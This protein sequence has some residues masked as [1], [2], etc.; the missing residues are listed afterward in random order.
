MRVSVSLCLGASAGMLLVGF[1]ETLQGCRAAEVAVPLV[2]WAAVC[3]NLVL[4]VASCVNVLREILS[5][6]REMVRLGGE[7]VVVCGWWGKGVMIPWC[8]ICGYA[9]FGPL[10]L[11][12]EE[13]LCIFLGR[14][15]ACGVLR[16]H[17]RYVRLP[18]F[19]GDSAM[20]EALVRRAGL[21]KLKETAWVVTY[22]REAAE[23]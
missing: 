21:V 20:G 7:A 17:G 19:R 9:A 13:L 8:D 5:V 6:H 23:S 1:W 3:A 2:T 10:R 15:R 22:G 11:Y 12:L 14:A 4:I 16:T 18:S